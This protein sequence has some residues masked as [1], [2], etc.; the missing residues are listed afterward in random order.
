MFISHRFFLLECLNFLLVPWLE[1]FVPELFI[2]EA[3]VVFLLA[4][5]TEMSSHEVLDSVVSSLGV[6]S[7]DARFVMSDGEGA[8]KVKDFH[9]LSLLEDLDYGFSE[10]GAFVVGHL[11]IW[12]L[13][14]LGGMNSSGERFS[15]VSHANHPEVFLLSESLLVQSPLRWDLSVMLEVPASASILVE[16][17]HIAKESVVH[18]IES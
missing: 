1:G 7:D 8:T 5:N 3:L 6:G 4:S 13:G 9:D 14:E 11:E 16:L 12:G 18:L 2:E 10:G 17:N 15:A